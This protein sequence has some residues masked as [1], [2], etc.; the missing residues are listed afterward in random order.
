MAEEK[1]HNPLPKEVKRF[2]KDKK[3]LNLGCGSDFFGDVRL[4]MVKTPATTIVTSIDKKLPLKDNEFDV[5]YTQFMFEHLVNPNSVLKEACRVLKKGGTI[6]LIT[7]NAGF[8]GFHS[9]WLTKTLGTIHY[10]GYR[11]GDDMHY[12][13]Y[14]PEH[15]RN[16]LEK[17]G[18]KIKMI[19][20]QSYNDLRERAWWKEIIGGLIDSFFKLI[21]L[22]QIAGYS[23]YAEGI[24]K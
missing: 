22:P 17:A 9:G 11:V 20:Y 8:W 13:L 3:I 4:D 15:I 16:H 2:G 1:F 19:K 12:A 18:F 21:G 6:A 10:G 7:D 24:K 5:V 23:I 14:T